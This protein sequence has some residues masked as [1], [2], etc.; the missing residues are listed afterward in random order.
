M[1]LLVNLFERGLAPKP[2]EDAYICRLP[3][4]ESGYWLVFS[5]NNEHLIIAMVDDCQQEVITMQSSYERLDLMLK[6]LQ[7]TAQEDLKRGNP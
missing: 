4:W 6:L 2:Y 3:G 7:T 1:K 5:D